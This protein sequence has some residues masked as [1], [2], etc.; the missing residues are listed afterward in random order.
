[1]FDCLI[2][3]FW[4]PDSSIFRGQ[5]S[6]CSRAFLILWPCSFSSMFSILYTCT[7]HPHKNFVRFPEPPSRNHFISSCHGPGPVFIVSWNE[8]SRLSQSIYVVMTK[9]QSRTISRR[10]SYPVNLLLWHLIVRLLLLLSI[11]KLTSG[12][13]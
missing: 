1:M 10:K 9:W 2:V 7:R 6:N 3:P 4:V 8:A 11:K 12:Q 5:R 13:D